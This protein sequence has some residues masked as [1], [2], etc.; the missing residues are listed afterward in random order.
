MV[1]ANFHK[2]AVST[3]GGFKEYIGPFKFSDGGAVINIIDSVRV[4]VKGKYTC[5]CG[6]TSK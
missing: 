3:I 4:P 5:P 1:A 2:A 6:K